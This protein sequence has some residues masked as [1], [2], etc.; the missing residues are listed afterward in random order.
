MK[1]CILYHATCLQAMSRPAYN[2]V[3]HYAKAKPAIIFA[4][5]R[6]HAKQMALDLMT[7]TAGD[8]NPGRFL[9]VL[10]CHASFY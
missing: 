1:R 3:L 6:R 8:A 7:Y 4:P 10:I 2:A 9:K 5:T